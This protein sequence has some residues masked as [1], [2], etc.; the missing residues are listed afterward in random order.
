MARL[1]DVEAPKPAHWPDTVRLFVSSTF[2]DLNDERD[3]LVKRVFPELRR[4]CRQ[5]GVAWAEV[6]LRWGISDEEQAEGRVLGV[7]LD[8]IDRCRPFF[9]GILGHRYG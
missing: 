4:R 1:L 5:R 3:E 6:D 2:V 9:I 8:E 7:C